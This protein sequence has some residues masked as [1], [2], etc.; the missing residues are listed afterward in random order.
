MKNPARGGVFREI[1][2]D[3]SVALFLDFRLLTAKVA[4]VVELGATN[5]TTANNLNVIDNRRVN[6]ELTLHADLE[7]HLTN[8]EGLANAF[9]RAAD[10]DALEDLNT[11]AVTLD[12]VYVNLDSVTSAEGWDVGTKARRVYCVKNVHVESQSVPTTG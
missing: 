12:D 3:L 8:G 6:G 9:T 5:V 4:Q 11:R 10:N 1:V 7:R 2:K